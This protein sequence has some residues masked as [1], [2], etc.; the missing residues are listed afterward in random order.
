MDATQTPQLVV[1]DQNA[2]SNLALWSEDQPMWRQC[3]DLLQHGV[4]TGSV[5]CPGP[6]ETFSETIALRDSELRLRIQT[7]LRELSAGWFIKLPWEI[8]AERALS[9]IRPEFDAFPFHFVDEPASLD[10]DDDSIAELKCA[11]ETLIESSINSL[12]VP[13]FSKENLQ[14]SELAFDWGVEWLQGIR[15]DLNRLKN[16]HAI[17]DDH[18]VRRCLIR[19]FEEYDV[20]NDEIR[21]LLI[22]LKDGSWFS[23]PYFLCLSLLEG[24][25]FYQTLTMGRHFRMNSYWDFWRAA[26]AFQYG[27]IFVSDG[28]LISH[29]KELELDCAGISLFKVSEPESLAAALEKIVA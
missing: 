16:G 17:P 2:I 27:N 12:P 3:L 5:I 11:E 28:P 4:R 20:T 1:L 10:P 15:A 8:M 14:V 9:R 26:A 19:V 6:P 7:L 21:Q 24:L 18:F 29:M 23:F 22:G 13:R 25:A